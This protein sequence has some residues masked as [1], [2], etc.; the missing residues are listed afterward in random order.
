MTLKD[1]EL[2]HTTFFLFFPVTNCLMSWYQQHETIEDIGNFKG[3]RVLS[4]GME[5]LFSLKK[6]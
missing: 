4:E 5:H 1:L 2:L 6:L 3:I